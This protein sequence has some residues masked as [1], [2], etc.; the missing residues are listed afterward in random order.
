MLKMLV[1]SMVMVGVLSA[2]GKKNE[3]IKRKAGWTDSAVTSEVNG[4]VALPPPFAVSN[5]QGFC[6]CTTDKISVTYDLA[7]YQS[8]GTLPPTERNA[9]IAQVGVFQNECKN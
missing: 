4:C 7:Y 2:C 9:L 1:F 6:Q 8:A 5:K 3:G